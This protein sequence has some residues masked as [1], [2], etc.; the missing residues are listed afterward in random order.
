IPTVEQRRFPVVDEE[1]G[2][3]AAIVMFQI[4]EADIERERDGETVVRHY[5]PRSLYLFEAFKIRDGRVQQIE[6]TMR[7]LEYGLTLDWPAES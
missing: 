5:D 6:A 1:R 3:V 7:D 2:V 4:P